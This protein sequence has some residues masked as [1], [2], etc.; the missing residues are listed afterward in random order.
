MK[1]LH[2]FRHIAIALVFAL[3]ASVALFA[4]VPLV[5]FALTVALALPAISLLYLLFLFSQ[6]EENTGRISCLML[7]S[8]MT[9]GIWIFAPP[10]GISLALHLGAIWLIRSLYFYNGIVGPLIDLLL[11][12]SSV[13][14]ALWCYF[15]TGSVFLSVWSLFLTQAFFVAIPPLLKQQHSTENR[16]TTTIREFNEARG[17]AEAA[18]RHLYTR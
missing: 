2:L 14:V 5:G 9:L 7:W 10:L 12:A 3:I 13:A 15:H 17:S 6:A 18:L 8:A 11:S 4:L 1:S 16:T